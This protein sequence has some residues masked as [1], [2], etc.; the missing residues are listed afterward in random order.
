MP[1][2]IQ[3]FYVDLITTPEGSAPRLKTEKKNIKP[4]S[5]RRLRKSILFFTLFFCNL[6]FAQEY[7]IAHYT[8]EDG[9][10]SSEVYA[11]VQDQAGNLWIG[12]FGGGLCK[13][14]GISFKNF[15]VADGLADNR[16]LSLFLDKQ[17]RLWIGTY[18]G[19]ISCLSG[20]SFKN[21]TEKD[22]L[23]NSFVYAIAEENNGDLLFA[24]Y[25]GGINRFDGKKFKLLQGVEVYGKQCWSVF[26]DSKNNTWIGSESGM[27]RI[28]QQGKL[29]LFEKKN[30]LPHAAVWTIT[31]DKTGNIWAGTYGG[32]AIK[33]DGKLF[34]Q[35]L[36]EDGLSNNI[37]YSITA[38][39]SGQMWFGTDAGGVSVRKDTSFYSIT[40]KNGLSHNRV[41]NLFL[42]REENM[43]IGTDGGLNC[44]RG[45]T[46]TRYSARDGLSD[47]KILSLAQ[48]KSGSYWFGTFG[49]GLDIVTFTNK[50]RD[51]IASKKHFDAEN[52]LGSNRV[53][54]IFEDSRGT[55]WVGTTGGL[56]V[57][58]QGKIVKSFSMKSGLPNNSVFSIS[59]DQKG[60]I[61]M[62]SDH[63]VS[64]FNGK[65]FTNYSVE[66]GLSHGRVRCIT[67]D[68]EGNMWL[69]TYAGGVTKYDGKKFVPFRD[70]D[71]L[72]NSTVYSIVTDEKGNCWFAT[73]G[74]GVV[75][76]DPKQ[77]GEKKFDH[78][79]KKDELGSD[80]VYLL[81]IDRNNVLWIGT[82][83]GLDA[84]DLNLYYKTGKKSIRHFGKS[85][86]FNGIECSQNAV[87][88]DSE[89]NTWFGT[90]NGAIKYRPSTLAEKNLPPQIAITGAHLFFGEKNLSAF[91]DGAD[92][93]T[94]LPINLKLP[95]D[96]NHLTF[97]FVGVNLSNPEG[98]SYR[99]RME[100]FDEGWSP[101]TRQRKTTYSNLPPGKYTFRVEAFGINGDEANKT[102]AGFSFTVAPPFWREWWFYL[103]ASV[104][105]ILVIRF[106]MRLRT[107]K[108]ESL[109]RLLDKKVKEQTE[110]LV[111]KNREKE[112]LLKEIHHRVKNN[113]QLVSSLLNLQS[114][115]IHDEKVLGA[116]R[117]S[118]NRV[119][120]MALIHKKL[121]QTE[122]LATL[123]FREYIEQLVGII[124]DSFY[125]K[126]R[127]IKV[128]VIAKDIFFDVDTAIPLG[129]M[130]TELV[131]NSYK[132]A[133]EQRV[134][135]KISIVIEEKESYLFSYT[136]DG[137]GLPEHFEEQAVTSLGLLLVQML[138]EQLAGK[139]EFVRGNG[140][141]FTLEF[142]SQ[143]LSSV[144]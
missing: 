95:Y 23:S 42:D 102:S 57:F 100:N 116:I 128:E 96:Q 123:D 75:C 104:C 63:G 64:V 51:E 24:T 119:G 86:G 45:K 13:Y 121:Y 74:N 126:G 137:C 36:V 32:G 4:Q 132:Y 58:E 115:T 30:G 55:T 9:I 40:E 93:L 133:F 3:A 76:Y 85:E 127:E 7:N 37:V 2:Q 129:L 97:D 112:V 62:G 118:Q 122:D 77:A 131:S 106:I 33:Y 22:G 98:V 99:F 135:G 82:I 59:E 10:G 38:D 35:F 8:S 19:G 17:K 41:R 130:I 11:T 54:K 56:S 94:G 143:Q 6:I 5:R 29:T 20:T 47:D 114:S 49:A 14:N 80:A 65:S 50:E 134:T 110:E 43:W 31:E 79:T 138:S 18:G 15:T 108:I 46:F 141:K 117:E 68:K 125:I 69:G 21:F 103:L 73:F 88:T 136:D 39:N 28:D 120:S 44:Y 109:N 66:D 107:K 67:P 142:S 144:H 1:I 92:K 89:N 111:K 16:V 71:K 34:T 70:N 84:M 81:N 48:D 25:G 12:T 105:G 139:H 60:N 27:T 101:V 52:G 140:F 124:S 53:W 72:N 26:K 87:F 61:W 90:I 91:A 113:L 83:N 78:I